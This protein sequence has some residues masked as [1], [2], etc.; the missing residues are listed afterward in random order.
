MQVDNYAE[1]K[2]L[3]EK[4]KESLPFKVR[5]GKEL[6]KTIRNEGEKVSPNQEFEVNS[7][8]YSGDDGGIMCVIVIGEEEKQAF[9]TSLTF[10]KFDPDH[11]LAP[12]V[13]AYQK[14]RTYGLKLQN[15]SNVLSELRRLAI[16]QPSK[17][18]SRKGGFGN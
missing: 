15:S 11:P 17:K 2:A 1:A 14:R 10:V 16:E 6:L 12:E 8:N 18:K 5:P 3:T 4:L 7:V 13:T 9:V